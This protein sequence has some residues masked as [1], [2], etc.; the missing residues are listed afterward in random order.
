[1]PLTFALSAIQWRRTCLAMRNPVGQTIRVSSLPFRVIGELA[2]KGQSPYGQ[3]QDDTMILPYTTV[4]K[5]LAGIS[6]L[7]SINVSAT[8]IG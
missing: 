2:A 4:M 5:K 3:D 6:W 1:M 7:Q 8:I